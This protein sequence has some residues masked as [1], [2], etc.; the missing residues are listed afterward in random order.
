M[1]LR[2][3]YTANGIG[4]VILLLLLYVSR[5]RTQQKR[6]EDRLFSVMVLGVMLGC[7]ME[8]FG[9][10]V[11]SRL[12]PG[13]RL[14]N[15]I[16]N[17]YLYTANLLLP[18]CVMVYVDLGL[19]GDLRR[20]PRK[21]KLQIIV[22]AVMLLADV[23]NLFIPVSFV[24]SPENVYSRKPFSYVYYF[25]IL[26]FCITGMVVTWRYEKENGARTFFS[27]R[28]FLLPILVGAGLQFLFYGLSLAWLSAAVGLVGLFM[29]QQNELAYVDSL[30]DTYNRQY[31]NQILSAWISRER[32]F[33]GVMLDIDR[34]KSIN[35]NFGHSEG[36]RA[37]KTVA[38]TLKKARTGHELV[39]RFAGDEFIGREIT[40]DED[41]LRAY[42]D[43]VNSLLEADGNR[44]YPISLSWG[45]SR[46]EGGGADAFMKDM[47][48]KMYA[49][50][51]EHHAK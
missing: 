7:F 4:I 1:D 31:L 12:F 16:A 42:M 20:I 9:Y 46:Y 45:V 29:M 30:A 39:F 34:F 37:L 43:K 24:I 28:M 49:M 22:G 11:D 25:V 32:S 19:F 15:Y 51:A 23:V 38:D 33:T 47:D 50:K 10:S 36:D 6:M 2:S 26:Y 3:I 27:V 35:D 18:F 14:L 40:D 21:Y 8:A 41:G 44:P 48:R 13:A 17:T 5:S